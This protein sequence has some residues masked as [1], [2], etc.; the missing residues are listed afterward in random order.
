M[1]NNVLSLQEQPLLS[2]HQRDIWLAQKTAT[3]LIVEHS[4]GRSTVL[5]G[6][7]SAI[8]GV[9][10]SERHLAI[11]NNR[12]IVIYKIARPDEHKDSKAKLLS[13]TQMHT[14]S[15][16]DCVQ[17]FIWSE[18]LIVLCRE[19]IK[20]YSLGGVILQEIFFNDTEGEFIQLHHAERK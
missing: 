19:N 5:H 16:P 11:T 17:L 7:I 3:Q 6:D 2:A 15:D 4:S 12:S 8:T 9:C 13:I 20:L 10:L 14:F 1:S 18:T